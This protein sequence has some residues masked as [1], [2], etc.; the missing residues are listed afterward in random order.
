MRCT[1]RGESHAGPEGSH[2]LVQRKRGARPVG[3]HL[4]PATNTRQDL[5]AA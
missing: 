5:D 3:E 1:A 4:T 2:R